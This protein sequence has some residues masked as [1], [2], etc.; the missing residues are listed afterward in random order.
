MTVRQPNGQYHGE[1]RTGRIMG[2]PATLLRC[3]SAI[4]VVGIAVPAQGATYYLNTASGN[5][6]NPGTSAQPWKTLDQVESKAV[7]GDIVIIQQA[8]AATYAA[9]WPDHVSYKAQVLQQFGIT[10]RFDRDYPVGQ[11]VTGD[12]WVVGP[13]TIVEFSPASVQSGNRIMNG[14]MI[15]PDPKV[16]AIGYDNAVC[17]N[18]IPY[19]ASLNIAYNVSASNPR[20]VATHS[21]IVSAISV[22]QGGARPQ[23]SRAAVLTVLPS[24]APVGSFR[25]PYSGNDKSVKFNKSM[26]DYSVLRRMPAVSGTPSPQTVAAYFAAPWLDHYPGWQG[27]YVHPAL[28]MPNYGREMHTQ[29]SMG[30]LMLHMDFTNEQK[31]LLLCRFVQ[32]GIDLYGI[33]EAGGREVWSNDGGVAGGRKWPILFAGIILGDTGMKSIGQKSGDYLYQNGY[34]PGNCPPDYIH[35]GEDDQTFYVT[36]AD[37]NITNSPAASGVGDEGKIPYSKSDIG[38]PEWAIR[39]ATA[40]NMSNKSIWSAYRNVA[41][42]PFDGTALAALLTE[43]GK[44][45]W[46]HNAFFDYTDRYM[47]MTASGGEFEGWW[48]GI[49]KYTRNMWDRYRAQCGPIW[50]ASQNA[51]APVL[52]LIGNKQAEVGKPLTFTVTATDAP[53]DTLTYSATGLP[54]GATF[55]NRVF[56]WTPGSVGSCQVT[57]TVSDGTEQDSETITITVSQPNAAPVLGSIGNKSTT[58]NQALSF[59]IGATD[60]D[61]DSITYTATGLPSGASFSGQTF[62]WTPDFAQAGAY[63]V[64]FTASDGKAQD[65]ETVTISVA[66]VNRPPALAAIGDRSV[67]EDNTLALTLSAADPDGTGLTYSATG[68]PSGANFTGQNFTWTPAADQ[69]GPHEIT[70]IVSDGTFSDSETITVTVVGAAADTSAPVVA[71]QSPAPGAIQVALNNLITFHVTDAG[72]GVNAAS[73]TVTLDDQIVYQGNTPLYTSSLGRCIR[74]GSKNDYEFIYQNNELFDFDHEI[75]LTVN[76]ADQA[77]NVMNEAAYSFATEMRAFGSNKRVSKT[78][79]AVKGGPV[80]VGDAAGN[81]WAAWHAGPVGARDIFVARLPAGQDSFNTPVQITTHSLDQCNPDLAL[82]ANGTLYVVWQDN[83]RGN[84]GIYASVSTDGQT[85]SKETAVVD[86]N[87]NQTAPSVAV[88]G[89]SPSRA[90]VAWQDDRNGN[91]DIYVASSTNAFA[92]STVSRV[93]TNTADQTEPDMAVGASNTVYL[94]WTDERSGQ[95]DLYAAASNASWANVALVTGEGNQTSPA[96]AVTPGSST[97]HLLWVD[98]ASGNADIYYASSNGLPASPLIGANIIDDTTGAS[99]TAPAIACD[100]GGEVFACWQDTR[101]IGAYGSDTDV[102][103]TELS[104]GA[105]KTNILVGD[106]GAKANQIEPAIAVS[107]DGQPYIVWTDSRSMSTEIY[108]AAT[109]YLDSTP[110]YAGVVNPA[111]AATIGAAP[112]AITKTSDVSVVVPAGAC[113]GSIRVTISKVLNPMVSSVDCLGSYDFGPSGIEFSQPVTVTIPYQVATASRRARAYWYNSLTGALSQQGITDI[114]NITIQGN[115]YALRFKTTHFTPYY[116]VASDSDIAVSGSDG[117]SGGA[118]SMSTTGDGSPRH[119]LVP[120]AIVVVF[121]VILRLR[122]KKRAAERIRS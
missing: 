82:A 5:V 70:F 14:S 21:S 65:S 94:V 36:Q 3:I 105:A 11:F 51:T 75:L 20:V 29:I 25:P 27:D 115:L 34:G 2:R 30:A 101:N 37:V 19:Q 74:S 76:A 90:Y 7:A 15:N 32:L 78:S 52:S 10:W 17:W 71:R 35:F 16:G 39:H 98:S 88:D 80:T 44:E 23:L 117:G 91:Q 62:S 104:E 45:L 40:P 9:T 13:V 109:T 118:C 121:M 43:G 49:G 38:L 106:S 26:L 86:A 64:T 99:Q 95:A 47:A 100:V 77:G 69:I 73:V 102:Y 63:S 46:N 114:Q 119:L 67:D 33:I 97:L 72:K 58:E 83:R 81:I 1:E 8:D 12:F 53:G 31:E 96:L 103:F 107:K 41:G 22:P 84:W 6:S 79:T 57:F 120:Y 110:L 48:S 111:A 89:A 122:D 112:T 56:A 108:C 42:P 87:D 68:L 61:S 24:P 66:N 116:L 60:A 18:P 113:Q 92:S 54:T 59:A 50:P 4:W 85:F 28:N 55:A 93:T